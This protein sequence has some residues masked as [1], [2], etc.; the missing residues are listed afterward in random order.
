MRIHVIG[1]NLRGTGHSEA[2]H[3][4]AEACA[5]VVRSPMYRG[6]EHKSDRETVHDFA[7]LIEVAAYVYDFE[8]NPADLIGDFRLFPCASALPE[9]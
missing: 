9:R 4:H 8:D 7:S 3:V 2:F 5:D 6:T 1:P